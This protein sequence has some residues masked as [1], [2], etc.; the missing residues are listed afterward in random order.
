MVRMS[1]VASLM[2]W[3][4]A[5]GG[6]LNA[7]SAFLLASRRK[8]DSS[9]MCFWV[10]FAPAAWTPSLTILQ[11]RICIYMCQVVD[12]CTCIIIYDIMYASIPKYK[13]M[14]ISIVLVHTCVICFHMLIDSYRL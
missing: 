4:V 8:S 9:C 6:T 1:A 10:A 13:C 14:C 3:W 5:G 12:V 7:L 2:V 11:T